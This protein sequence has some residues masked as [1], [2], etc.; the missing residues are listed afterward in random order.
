M[1]PKRALLYSSDSP[2][3]A[4]ALSA[5]AM[6]LILFICVFALIY[7]ALGSAH[8]RFPGDT[9]DPLLFSVMMTSGTN[10]GE[11]EPTTPTGKAIVMVQ[12]V[13]SS[14]GAV[15]IVSAVIAHMPPRLRPIRI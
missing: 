2:A 12:L 7:A 1:R 3:H 15:L 14:I 9:V 11:Y 5:T 8:F 13:L 10:F 4:L 6:A